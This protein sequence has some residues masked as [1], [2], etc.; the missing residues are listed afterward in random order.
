MLYEMVIFIALQELDLSY[1]VYYANVDVFRV[2]ENESAVIFH[3]NM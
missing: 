1:I 2:M 3:A